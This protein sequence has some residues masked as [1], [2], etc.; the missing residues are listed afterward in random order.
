MEKKLSL[1][2]ADKTTTILAHL[3]YVVYGYSTKF[4]SGSGRVSRD[5]VSANSSNSY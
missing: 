5:P 1:I 2:N 4:L 3:S